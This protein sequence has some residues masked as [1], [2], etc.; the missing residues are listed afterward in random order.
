[1]TPGSDTYDVLRII[2]EKSTAKFRDRWFKNIAAHTKD[3]ISNCN[4]EKK[5]S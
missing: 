3:N 5:T 1:M 4:S 2:K